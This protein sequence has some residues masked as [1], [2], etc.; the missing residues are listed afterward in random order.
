[1]RMQVIVIY[2]LTCVMCMKQWLIFIFFF[3]FTHQ[4]TIMRIWIFIDEEGRGEKNVILGGGTNMDYK[5]VEQ[6]HIT[7]LMNTHG[8][9][10]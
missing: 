3:S 6:S 9:L 7:Q 5:I 10:Y 8:H 4:A 2:S 1:M